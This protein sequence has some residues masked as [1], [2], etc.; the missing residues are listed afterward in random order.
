VD[1]TLALSIFKLISAGGSLRY[2]R[3]EIRRNMIDSLTGRYG[4]PKYVL[5]WFNRSWIVKSDNRGRTIAREFDKSETA[6]AGEKWKELMTDTE[7]T[8][9]PGRSN[10][11][12]KAIFLEVFKD[13]WPQKT[14]EHRNDWTSLPLLDAES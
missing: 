12:E 10:Y 5:R 2:M 9:G 14:Q 1:A 3:L 8:Y 4:Y 6:Q 11:E 7:S 13:I